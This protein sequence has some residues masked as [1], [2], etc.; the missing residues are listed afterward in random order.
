MYY[1]Y[2]Y[3]YPYWCAYY[4]IGFSD[5]YINFHSSLYADERVYDFYFLKTDYVFNSNPNN[6]ELFMSNAYTITTPKPFNYYFGM[7]NG[8][9]GGNIAYVNQGNYIP[10]LVR[11]TG[12]MTDAEVNGGVD[13]L[14]V[15]LD[16]LDV[17]PV[18]NNKYENNF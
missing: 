3:H 16:G 13:R 4:P 2:N 5:V 1:S 11:L 15:F 9:T 14:F 10:T 7:A 6:F 17:F 12:Y 18:S 8:W